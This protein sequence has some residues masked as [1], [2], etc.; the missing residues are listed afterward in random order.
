MT[1]EDRFTIAMT[2]AL[3]MYFGKV[4]FSMS[5]KNSFLFWTAC[6]SGK[7]S[8]PRHASQLGTA[9]SS[10]LFSAAKRA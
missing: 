2:F 4:G 1:T 9:A 5:N 6:L 7:T 10:Y 3:D 8:R